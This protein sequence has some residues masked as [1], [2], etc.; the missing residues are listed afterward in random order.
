L[1]VARGLDLQGD[2]RKD[3]AFKPRGQYDVA[4]GDELNSAADEK[5]WATDDYQTATKH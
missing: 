5:Y 4:P 2:I 1:Q 3:G